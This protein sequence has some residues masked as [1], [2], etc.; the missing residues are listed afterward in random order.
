[1]AEP[2]TA[3]ASAQDRNAEQQR[4]LLGAIA[5]QG[6]AGAAAYKQA[7]DQNQQLQQAALNQAAKAPS[8]QLGGTLELNASM[9]N[10]A[11]TTFNQD[12]A[13]QTAA[14]SDYMGQVG[15][16]I[17]IVESRTRAS[18]EQ[19]LADLQAKREQMAMDKE[20]GMLSLQGQREQLAGQREARA[21]A[22]A[23]RAAEEQGQF[24][25]IAFKGGKKVFQVDDGLT[26]YQR[27]QLDNAQRDD[28]RADEKIATKERDDKRA[29][30]LESLNTRWA[31]GADE[32]GNV[33]SGESYKAVYDVVNGT[34]TL[35]QALATYKT[36]KGKALSRKA[37]E[38]EVNR[39]LAIS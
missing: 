32:K 37:I 13:R 28:A 16:A 21:A 15:A 29:A 34:M 30:Y 35:D 26:P 25:E 1:M 17:P 11:Q 24:R 19:T 8:A 9:L 38:D 23:E 5:E 33:I 12:I 14:N 18:V 10:N 39:I 4:A 2:L 3:F 36:P 27:I 22:A 6:S 7:Q 20:M 31:N